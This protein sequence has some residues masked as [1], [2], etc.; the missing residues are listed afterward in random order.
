VIVLSD[1]WG[2]HSSDRDKGQNKKSKE[3]PK[4]KPNYWNNKI[5]IQQERCHARKPVFWY[6]WTHKKLM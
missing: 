2:P 4:I 5:P 1:K 3:K 6:K